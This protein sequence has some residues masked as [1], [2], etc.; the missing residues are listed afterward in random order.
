MGRG[1]GK[2]QRD[3]LVEMLRIER[4]QM[5]KATRYPQRVFVVDVFNALWERKWRAPYEDAEERQRTVAAVRDEEIRREAAAGDETA[6]RYL[7]LQERLSKLFNRPKS[8]L[9]I[10]DYPS[11]IEA[12][13]NPSRIMALLERRGL[14][15]RGSR[16]KTRGH[17][18]AAQLTEAGRAKAIDIMAE[19]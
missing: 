17:F 4:E 16:L 8:Q 14:I 10:R 11:A 13:V 9:R 15:E 12:D 5:S 6:Q 7:Y 3:V 18:S 19:G 1:L 2:H